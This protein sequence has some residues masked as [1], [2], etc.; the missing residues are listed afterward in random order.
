MD[1][2]INHYHGCDKFSQLKDPKSLRCLRRA[3]YAIVSYVD[4]K[5]GE[6]L[7]TLE[8]SGLDEDTFVL[9]LSDHGDMLGE[10]GMVQK[11]NFYE[12]SSR[13]P[14]IIRFPDRQHAGTIVGQPTSLVDVLPTVLELAN[15]GEHLP[16]DGH[17]VMG[18]ID[19]RETVERHIFSEYHSN[20]VYSTCFMV[21]RGRFKYIHIHG[22][23]DQLFDLKNDPGEWKNLIGQ[24]RT[25]DVEREY[26]TLILDTFDPVAIEKEV[27]ATIRKRQLLRRWG[28][29]TG[30]QWAYVPGF[31]ADKNA[32]A[33]Y[34]P[35]GN[36]YTGPSGPDGLWE[37]ENTILDIMITK[38]IE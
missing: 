34:L 13:I 18:L 21:R 16:V 28:E 36:S 23:Q 20:G 6:L 24:P 30:V 33:Q 15:V 19:G 25:A 22:Q 4:R 7:Q 10:K 8:E 11:R 35:T 26:K 1:R 38:E 3:Y 37:N 5:V 32:V 9:F 12:W 17:S 14:F 27:L 2:W 31:D 29:A